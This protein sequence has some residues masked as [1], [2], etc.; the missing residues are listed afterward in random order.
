MREFAAEAASALNR[1][2]TASA[3]AA[4]QGPA[5]Y[6]VPTNIGIL[7]TAGVMFV[8]IMGLCYQDHRKRARMTDAGKQYGFA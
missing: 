4:P 7:I 5:P 2:S 1:R 8:L 6:E 3:T